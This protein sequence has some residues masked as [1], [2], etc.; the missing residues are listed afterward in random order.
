MTAGPLRVAGCALL[1]L[2]ACGGPAA[3][4]PA[5]EVLPPGDLLPADVDATLFGTQAPCRDDPDACPSGA[6]YYSRCEGLTSVDVRWLQEELARALAARTEGHEALRERVAERLGRVLRSQRLD[7][8]TR[9]RAILGLEAVRAVAVLE[10]A[11]ADLP[12]PLAEPTVLALTRLGSAAGLHHA[13]ALTEVDRLPIAAE[14][15]RALGASGLSEALPGL[16]RQLDPDRTPEPAIVIRLAA[17]DGIA[18]LGDPRAIAPLV[19]LLERAPVGLAFPIAA[20]L[21]RLTGAQLGVEPA[22]WRAWLAANPL[23]VAPDVGG[24][25]PAR[26]ARGLTAP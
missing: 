22:T 23:A 4:D 26:N 19:D 12:E 5:D 14:A 15:L 7:V 6:C 9:A 8:P 10:G 11:L 24:E 17:L 21:R 16:L 3:P 2:L 18:T 25:P 13:L 1:A 20:T